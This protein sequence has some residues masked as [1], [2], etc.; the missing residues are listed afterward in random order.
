MCKNHT[1]VCGTLDMLTTKVVFRTPKKK[2]MKWE[3]KISKVG[4]FNRQDRRWNSEQKL[5]D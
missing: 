5:F 1:D 2:K 3:D 4:V